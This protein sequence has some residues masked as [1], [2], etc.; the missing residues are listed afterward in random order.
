VDRNVHDVTLNLLARRHGGKSMAARLRST[1]HYTRLEPL[2]PNS[3]HALEW[4][5]YRREVGRLLAESHEG[6]F[7]LIA[8]SEVLGLWPTFEEA[9]EEGRK[10]G[11][12]DAFVYEAMAEH[13]VFK[14]GYN[15]PCRD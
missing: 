10:R 5:I 1:I 12:A 6:K 9:M 14:I 15:K 4:E 7:V 13:E 11:L 3:R 8:G 2:I